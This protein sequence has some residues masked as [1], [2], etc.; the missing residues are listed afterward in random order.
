MDLAC[1][2]SESSTGNTTTQDTGPKSRTAPRPDSH[3]RL[4][5]QGKTPDKKHQVDPSLKRKRSEP[6]STPSVQQKFAKNA[7]EM[8]ANCGK[9]H[10]EINQHM[11]TRR[12]VERR[13]DKL[14]K[15]QASDLRK[16]R[17]TVMELEEKAKSHESLQEK[18]D[19]AIAEQEKARDNKATADD[20]MKKMRHKVA[21]L[22]QQCELW[23][24]ERNNA[25]TEAIEQ[26]SRARKAETERNGVK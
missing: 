16:A 5:L 14:L 19:K 23:R 9:Q 21:K 3:L 6:D 24:R 10:E 8:G 12:E 11:D 4:E 7:E 13:T 26:R 18:L 22:R 2:E 15:S 20:M 25:N 17:A 1:N